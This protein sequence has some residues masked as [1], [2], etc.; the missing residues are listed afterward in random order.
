MD[1]QSVSA[2]LEELMDAVIEVTNADKGFLILID[3]ATPTSRWP[4]TSPTEPPQRR[5]PPVRQHHRT[6]DADQRPLIVSDALHDEQFKTSESVMNLKLCSVMCA[7]LIAQGELLGILYVGNDNVVN[8]FEESSLDVLTI[9]A[10][11][12]SLILQNALLLD[13]SRPTS[14]PSSS[15]STRSASATSS[16]PVRRCARCSAP[17]RRS[18]PPT[19]AC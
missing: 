1:V 10:G 4:A 14:T 13:S 12:A 7:P 3:K 16:A 6:R 17:S 8:L 5:A 18:R 15:S 11:Q 19:S 2:L 9:F